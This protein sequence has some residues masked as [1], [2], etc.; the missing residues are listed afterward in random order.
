MHQPLKS[1]DASFTSLKTAVK[2]YLRIV[3]FYSTPIP[4]MR[5]IGE[6]IMVEKQHEIIL[7]QMDDTNV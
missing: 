2:G 7:Y 5:Q 6:C 1:T 4:V 3:S